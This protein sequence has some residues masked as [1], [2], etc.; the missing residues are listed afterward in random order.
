MIKCNTYSKPIDLRENNFR[1]PK[2]IKKLFE[3][4]RTYRKQNQIKSM[5]AF[6]EKVNEWLPVQSLP[7]AKVTWSQWETGVKEIGD[8]TYSC[9][10][11]F[12]R[13]N[14]PM[15]EEDKPIK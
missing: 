5:T 11:L 3:D 6:A 10:V 4:I 15:Q 13:E 2:D 8:S 9:I 14:L 1:M 7:T 12:L